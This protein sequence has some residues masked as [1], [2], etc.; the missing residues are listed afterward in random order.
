[1]S[2]KEKKHKSKPILVAVDLTK[3][4]KAALVFANKLA[5]ETGRELIVLHVI[6]DPANAPGFYSAKK[7]SGHLQPMEKVAEEMMNEFLEKIHQG[8]KEMLPIKKA[9]RILVR[10]LPENQIMNVAEK[11]DV[12]MIVMGSHGRSGLSKILLG[13]KADHAVKHSLVPVIIVK[14]KTVKEMIRKEEE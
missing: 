1:M 7:G 11:Q 6:H 9:R 8:S 14:H 3:F 5:S 2:K 10:G 12:G 13:S 4:S